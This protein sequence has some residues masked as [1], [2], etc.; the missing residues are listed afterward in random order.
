MKKVIG[1]VIGMALAVPA[2]ANMNAA[3]LPV[4]S[5]EVCTEIKGPGGQ[6]VNK[7]C[8]EWAIPLTLNDQLVIKY[9]RIKALT[10][11]GI[12][13]LKYFQDNQDG[14]FQGL[15]QQMLPE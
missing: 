9:L 8:D 15:Q 4:F 2:F 5:N 11:S 3:N 6:A 10:E 7:L 1:M 14:N 12:E 13:I